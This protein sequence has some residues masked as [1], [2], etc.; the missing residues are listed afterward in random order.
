MMKRQQRWSYLPL[1]PGRVLHLLLQLLLQELTLGALLML[2][3]LLRRPVTFLALE[4]RQRV[5]SCVTMVP[6]I[7]LL[8]H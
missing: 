2:L 6:K 5:A 8:L 1:Q 3:L 7:Q 4:A